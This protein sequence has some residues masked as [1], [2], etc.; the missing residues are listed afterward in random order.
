MDVARHLISKWKR[1]ATLICKFIHP[2]IGAKGSRQVTQGL[3]T[4]HF[5]TRIKHSSF[6]IWDSGA[7]T[8]QQPANYLLALALFETQNNGVPK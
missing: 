3:L 2:A 5:L 8:K 6:V 1:A 4:C 7:K